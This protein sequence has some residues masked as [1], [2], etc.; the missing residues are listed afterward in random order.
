[1]ALKILHNNL[2]EKTCLEVLPDGV[3]YFKAAALGTTRSFKFAEIDC[4]L[5]SPSNVLSFQVGTE[6]FSIPVKP[7]DEHHKT[8]VNSMLNELRKRP[9]ISSAL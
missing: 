9:V 2:I 8:V 4:V 1:M 3:N 6:V 5:L 7:S